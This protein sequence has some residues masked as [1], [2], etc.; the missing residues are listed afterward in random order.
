MKTIPRYTSSQP[1]Q[2]QFITNADACG[3][4][5]FIQLKRKENICLY[6]RTNVED[7]RPMG[8]EVIVVKQ[9]KAGQS[10]PGGN[11]VKADYE[12]YPGGQAFGKTGWSF[13]SLKAAED[14][15]NKVVKK[16]QTSD[17]SSDI[18]VVSLVDIKTNPI[19]TLTQPQSSTT[20]N[21]PT[22]E[23]T[24]AQFATAN[25]LP[26][27]GVVYNVIQTLVNK[28]LIKVSQRVKMGAGRPT[29]LYVKS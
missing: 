5:I 29:V 21:I 19:L 13:N 26:V 22:G 2:T 15:F 23:F 18:V 27:R 1:I 4:H 8:F 24:Q 16:Q 7:G 6:S 17:K 14:R 12:S 25:L 3:D 11:V 9:I 28:G 20:Q 10:L